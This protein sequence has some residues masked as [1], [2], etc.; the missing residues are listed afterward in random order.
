MAENVFVVLGGGGIKGMA[1]AGAWRAIEETGLGVTEIL[2]T[3]IGGLVAACLAGGM[4]WPRLYE[5]AHVFKKRDIVALNRWAL[6]FNGIRQP[7]VFQGEPL[8]NFINTVL[9]VARF[10]ELNLA[11]SVNAVDLET[12]KTKWFGAAGDMTVPVADAV[13]A[14]CALPL[15]Y[16]P[17]EINGELYVDGGV[18]D[19]LP[20]ELAAARGAT[21]IIAIDVGAGELRDSGDT[22]AKGLVAIHHRVG[23]IMGYARKRALLENW[24]GPRLIYVRP[25]LDAYS[26]FD[27]GRTDFFLD[28]GYRA[29]REAL[30]EAGYLLAAEAARRARG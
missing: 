22:V 15:F 4:G 18:N 11:V 5:L 13:Y 17:A 1:H 21:L 3:S 9:P 20:I 30:V 24:A 23:E 25:R 6:L 16:P 28:E 27:F 7:S 12:G 19:G 26:T 29:T 2:G 10:D 14:T 8:R